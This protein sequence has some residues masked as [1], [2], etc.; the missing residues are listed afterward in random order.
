MT[1]LFNIT[2]RKL[3][4]NRLGREYWIWNNDKLYEQRMARENG[5]YQARNL[6]MN[7]RLLPNAR[8]VIDVGSNIGMNTIEYATWCKDI[9]SF[10][11]MK[12]SMELCKMNVDIARNAKL[13]GRY[14]DNKLKQVRHQPDHDD[15]WFKQADGTFA[16]L[17]LVGNIEFFEY[18]LGRT[19]ESIV[20]EQKINECSR[21][22]AVLLNGK[23]T[24][25]PTQ[26]A[27]QRTLDSFN[28]QDV[29]LIKIDV[30]G[31]ELF[32]LE[33]SVDTI[34][35]CQPVV[36]VELRDTHCKR[37]GYK[38][39]DI[40]NLMMSLGDYV[41]CDFNGND[42]GTVYQKVSGVMDRFFVPRNIFAATE[43]KNKKV[44]PG[45]KK[46]KKKSKVDQ[47][48]VDNL[49]TVD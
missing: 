8:T 49:L 7:R 1:E 12:S 13:K 17:A 29:D 18:A 2:N 34:R 39:D 40:I 16:S 3:V 45:M 31:S 47:L 21:G 6:V 44:H 36:Q 35:R 11:P 42:L 10:E 41:M 9:K 46:I 43:F 20:M 48:V 25:N 27:E 32:V 33:G 4:I 26:T 15:G 30:E 14:W 23:S 5:P 22:D 28:F 37:F 38:C 24:N 19:N